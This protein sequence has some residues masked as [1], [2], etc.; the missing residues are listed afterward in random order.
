ME[1][2]S[3]KRM[4]RLFK[5]DGRS[6]IVAMDHGSAMNVFPDLLDT[7]SVLK[8]IVDNGADA[9]LTTFGILKNHWRVLKDSGIILRLDGGITSF[10]EGAKQYRQLF[11]VEDALRLGTDAVGCM[12]LP[13]SDYESETLNYLANICAEAHLWN[14]P[15]LAEMLPGGF[16]KELHTP[17]NIAVSAR[18]GVELGADIIKTEYPHDINAFKN[19]TRGVFKPVVVLGGTKSERY[20]EL[21]TMVKTAIDA[22]ASGVAVGRNIWGYRNPGAMT[23]ALRAIIHDNADVENALQIIEK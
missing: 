1:L 11:T 5:S 15:V 23:A 19:M 18:I 7:P 20:E 3:M 9:F 12:G 16:N 14:I 6:L 4:H 10:K 13:G 2:F 17:E 8:Q 22:G 21:F